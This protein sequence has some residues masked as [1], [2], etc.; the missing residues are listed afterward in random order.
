VLV[1]RVV[2][3]LVW[4]GWRERDY[5]AA[6]REAE[7][8]GWQWGCRE[9]LD[10]IREDWRAVFRG[11]TWERVANLTIPP[12]DLA[13]HAALLHRLRPA[14]LN[15]RQVSDLTP[16]QGL[17]M[18]KRLSIQRG[19]TL[20]D[21]N[22]LRDLP[23]LEDLH[24]EECPALREIGSSLSSLKKLGYLTFRAC[25]SLQSL[26]GIHDLPAL[27]KMTVC[28]QAETLK[29]LTGLPRLEELEISL[30]PALKNLEGLA[31]LPKLE[32]LRVSHC[33]SL[34]NLDG[35]RG[36]H[37][38]TG[39]DL[40]NCPGVVDFE[41][42]RGL[43]KLQGLGLSEC[44]AL[45]DLEVISG[46]NELT[47]LSQ[48]SCPNLENFEAIKKLPR[49]KKLFSMFCPKFT[50]EVQNGLARARPDLEIRVEWHLE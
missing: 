18:L 46:L 25:P 15:L 11:R 26:R 9:P 43:G 39:F 4:A 7:S 30:C 14:E 6:I 16:L 23:R 19:A 27:R 40:G 35:L 13:A 45:K 48:I 12:T 10:W 21:L 17:S 8:M 28:G 22:G 34:T 38:L 36:V 37:G 20:P 50:S 49:L 42:L 31:G 1:A 2:W 33:A 32:K 41:G 3:V 44:P 24:V 47:A 29:D 5:R